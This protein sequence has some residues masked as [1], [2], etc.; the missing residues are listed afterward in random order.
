[1]AGDDADTGGGDVEVVGEGAEDGFVG[2]AANR[3][4]F[5]R[6]DKFGDA[7]FLHFFFVRIWFGFDGNAHHINIAQ[8]NRA[9]RGMAKCR[10]MKAILW[11]EPSEDR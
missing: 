9:K 4:F 8:K 3:R 1:M 6:D 7:D 10:K 5:D 2:K 11:S